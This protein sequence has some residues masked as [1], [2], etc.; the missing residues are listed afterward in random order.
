MPGVLIWPIHVACTL[1]PIFV[2]FGLGMKLHVHVYKI[3]SFVPNP[4]PPSSFWL[5]YLKTG[6]WKTREQ[7]TGM[8]IVQKA[9]FCTD[10]N[11]TTAH[12]DLAH[13][14][15]QGWLRPHDD[16]VHDRGAQWLTS[17]F[18]HHLVLWTQ[19]A[20]ALFG[21]STFRFTFQ[22]DTRKLGWKFQFLY[23]QSFI[24][25]DFRLFSLLKAQKANPGHNFRLLASLKGK[26]QNRFLAFGFQAAPCRLPRVY[27]LVARVPPFCT[28]TVLPMTTLP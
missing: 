20:Y 26:S 1:V 3:N 23:P 17:S 12:K 9:A 25:L 2:L 10:R 11:E 13:K 24:I 27:P 8:G 15:L 21:H 16:L 22:L 18:T 6:N 28:C 4:S 5:Q 14:N 7:E 19:Q